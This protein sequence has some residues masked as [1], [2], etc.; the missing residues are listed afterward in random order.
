MSEIRANTV[1]DAAGTGPVTLT[2]Q[3]AAK[4]WVNFNGTGTI[5]A[6]DSFNL[7]SLTDG[8]TGTYTV[9]VTNAFG[10]ADYVP[11]ASCNVSVASGSRFVTLPGPTA[12]TA[13]AISMYTQLSS[14]TVLGDME[15]VHVSIHGDL[16]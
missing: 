9:N 5:A 3:S 10:S 6:R 4:A 16:A 11:N 13:S 14:T 12:P 2:K 7:A 1:S 8:G 15:F